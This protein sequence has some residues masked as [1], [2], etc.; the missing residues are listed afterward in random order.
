MTTD[1]TE[2]LQNLIKSPGWLLLQQWADIEFHATTLVNSIDAGAIDADIA[3]QVR[4]YT[5]AARTARLILGWPER[6]IA[7][8]R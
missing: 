8:P 4:D 1:Q 7:A 5:T 3:Q 6:R 2:H